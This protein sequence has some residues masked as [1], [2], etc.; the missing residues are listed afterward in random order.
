MTELPN[1]ETI[2][3]GMKGDGSEYAECVFTNGAM[4]RYAREPSERY[5]KKIVEEV[6]APSDP[7]SAMERNTVV[8]R[9]NVT[10]AEECLV[11]ALDVYDDYSSLD[12]LMQDWST[13]AEWIRHD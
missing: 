10:T 11:E 1:I 6:F 8:N 5:E 3:T 13:L 9:H 12:G 7:H 4:L 2:R